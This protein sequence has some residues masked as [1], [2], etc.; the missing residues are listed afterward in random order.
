MSIEHPLENAALRA[1]FVLLAFCILAY[2]YL[3]GASILNVMEREEAIARSAEMQTSIAKL[4][5]D[6]FAFA[7][8]IT[9][10]TGSML[11]LAPIRDVAY[12]HRPGTVGQANNTQK[13]I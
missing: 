4:E 5:N 7:Q 13:G 12:V 1:L 10:E 2:I 11:G 3:V 9:P 8:R 6:Y